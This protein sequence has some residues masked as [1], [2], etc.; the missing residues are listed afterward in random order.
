MPI[1]GIFCA[2]NNLSSPAVRP[3]EWVAV[4]P[5]MCSWRPTRK[6]SKR[7]VAKLK[8]CSVARV[9]QVKVSEPRNACGIKDGKLESQMDLVF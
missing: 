3:S 9:L 7:V 4:A 8:R 5:A 1:M 2:A 6:T